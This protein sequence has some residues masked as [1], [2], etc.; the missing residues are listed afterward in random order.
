M[1]VFHKC[2]SKYDNFI[3]DMLLTAEPAWVCLKS[4]TNFTHP[5]LACQKHLQLDNNNWKNCWRAQR[6][7]LRMQMACCYGL[8]QLDVAWINEGH[9]GWPWIT[10]TCYQS[11]KHAL[12]WRARE[13][14][15]DHQRNLTTFIALS[16]SRRG[17]FRA[18]TLSTNM[19]SSMP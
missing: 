12:V 18:W 19:L 11:T 4:L 5:L 2:Q 10:G 14:F 15:A 9:Q 16:V 7:C 8:A 3:I 17:Q 13:A 1:N 6:C